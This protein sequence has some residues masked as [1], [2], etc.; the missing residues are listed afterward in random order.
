[1]AL[2][3]TLHLPHLTNHGVHVGLFKDVENA[4]YLRQQLLEGNADFEYAFLDATT[5]IMLRLC[6]CAPILT[7][8]FR[9]CRSS[10][11]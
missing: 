11:Y 6:L 3:T 7:S 10:I 4:A 1:M 8:L 9:Y 5:V 2:V